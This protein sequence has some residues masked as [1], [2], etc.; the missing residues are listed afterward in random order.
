MLYSH[1]E[2]FIKNSSSYYLAF[3]KFRKLNYSELS[4][5]LLTLAIKS[6]LVDTLNTNEH[7]EQQR[8]VEFFTGE[9]NTRAKWNLD[10]AIDTKSNLNSG[11]L[12]NILS[13]LGIDNKDFEL[14]SNLIDSQLVKNRNTISH[15]NYFNM[16]KEEYSELHKQIIRLMDIFFNEVTNQVVLK[17]YK[18]SA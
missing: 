14:K 16:D 12:M 3:V 10:K 9:L 17:K 15:G 13:V 2:G 8:F 7:N 11:V 6:K 18:K 4:T 5:C 1:W